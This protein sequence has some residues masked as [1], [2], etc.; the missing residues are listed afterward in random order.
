MKTLGCA[1]LFLVY[2]IVLLPF[3]AL[4]ELVYKT[5][6]WFTEDLNAASED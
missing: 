6:E 1:M 4:L 5:L 2:V 3:I